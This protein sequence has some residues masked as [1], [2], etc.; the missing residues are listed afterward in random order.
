MQDE[1]VLETAVREFRSLKQLAERAIDQ[2]D[3]A[4]FFAKDRGGNSIAIMVKHLAGNMHSRW[5]DFL[6]SDGEKP[7]RHRD[8]EFIITAD[9]TRASLMSNWSTGWQLLFDAIGPLTPDDCGRVVTIRGEPHTVLQAVFRQLTHYSYHVGQIVLLAK[10]HA[11]GRWQTL[12]IAPGDSARFN[13][14]P[15]PYL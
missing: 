2:I 15:S 11:G 10:H 14:R 7:D 9:D 6:T 1:G 13:R 8:S 4:A 3:D 5:R 12:S